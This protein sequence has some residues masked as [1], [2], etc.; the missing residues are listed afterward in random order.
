MTLFSIYKRY[1]WRISLTMLLVFA[2][3]VAM[4][5]LPLVIGFAIDGLLVSSYNGVWQL[6]AVGFA[7]VII[8]SLRR[9]YDTRVYAGIYVNLSKS[10]VPTSTPIPHNSMPECRCYQN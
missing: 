8:G 9:V 6:A 4:L 3:A 1:K 10:P 2:E 7:V 5:L